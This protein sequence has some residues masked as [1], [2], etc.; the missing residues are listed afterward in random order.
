MNAKE[1]ETKAK[2][3]EACEQIVAQGDCAEV[4]CVDCPLFEGEWDCDNMDE[5]TLAELWLRLHP[6]EKKLVFS[7]EKYLT[8]MDEIGYRSAEGHV[9]PFACEG[10]TKEECSALGCEISDRWMEER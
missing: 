5:V 4:E 7:R 1:S 2:Q 9:W 3:R 8:A 10:K 6:T